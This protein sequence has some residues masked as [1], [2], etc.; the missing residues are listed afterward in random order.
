[1]RSGAVA[2]AER[3]ASAAAV[4][5]RAGLVAGMEGAMAGAGARAGAGMRSS[6][7]CLICSITALTGESFSGEFKC[8]DLR[9]FSFLGLMFTTVYWFRINICLSRELS[10]P[11]IITHSGHSKPATSLLF[12]IVFII[13]PMSCDRLLSF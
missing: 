6:S 12:N 10:K 13:K 5:R 3:G 4:A 1:M 9:K 11:Q 7:A 8:L 2:V